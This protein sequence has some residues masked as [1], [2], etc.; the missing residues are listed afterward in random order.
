MININ[1]YEEYF[2]DYCEGKLDDAGRREVLQF[3]ALHPKLRAELEEYSGSPILDIEEATEHIPQALSDSLRRTS[4]YNDADVPYFERLAVVNIE[5]IATPAEQLEYQRLIYENSEY[6]RIASQ[7][8]S[9][10]LVPDTIEYPYKQRLIVLP[11]WQKILPYA[12]AAAILAVVYTLWPIVDNRSVC[13]SLLDIDTQLVIVDM[14]ISTNNTNKEENNA[15]A[16]EEP[17]TSVETSNVTNLVSTEIS[18]TKRRTETS[19]TQP[20]QEIQ[21]IQEEQPEIINKSD[22]IEVA[23]IETTNN[24]NVDAIPNADTLIVSDIEEDP[25]P[26]N[27]V[28]TNIIDEHHKHRKR[29][30]FACGNVVTKVM[31]RLRPGIHIEIDRDID[32]EVSRVAMQTLGKTYSWQRK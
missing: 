1:N 9:T 12:A 11:L 3:V 4:S 5:K 17:K 10:I 32:G 19:P 24:D 29:F 18:H 23:A 8:S 13:D 22:V 7:Y 6:R 20:I 26:I 28:D 31:R 2:L 15:V 14:P 30:F 16:Q 21:Q 27:N 25:L